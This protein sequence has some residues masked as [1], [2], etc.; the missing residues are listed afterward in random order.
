MSF[1]GE[2]GEPKAAAAMRL[3]QAGGSGGS[4]AGEGAAD[5]VVSD[6]D[7]GD[8]GH[9][10]FGLFNSLESVGKHAKAVSD[11]AGKSLKSDGFDTGAAFTEVIGTWEKQVMNY[12]ILA[13][14]NL[15]KEYPADTL[16]DAGRTVGFLEQAR[17]LTIDVDESKDLRDTSWDQRWGY[18]LVGAIANQ[19]GGDIAQRGVDAITA[20][21]AEEEKDFSPDRGVNTQIRDAADHGNDKVNGVGGEK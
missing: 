18:H 10:A 5:Y 6:D 7:L 20:A 4:A 2:W 13:D 15:N 1:E 19:F 12:A 11:T 21:W 3:N 9:A 8:I 17:Q 16:R 14:I